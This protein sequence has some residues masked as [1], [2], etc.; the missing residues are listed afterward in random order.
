[1]ECAVI[2]HR[3][4]ILKAALAILIFG[5]VPAAVSKIGLNTPALGIVR[6]TLATAG[7]SLI[8]ASRPSQ[9]GAIRNDFRRA[10]PALA[11]MGVF[12]GLHWLTYFIAIKLGSPSMSELGFSTYGAQL[13]FLGW[14]FGFGRPRAATVAGIVLAIAGSAMCLWG[15]RLG[16]AP[17]GGL[18]V[19]VVSGTLYAALPLLHQRFAAVDAQLRTWAQFAFALPLFLALR[20]RPSGRGACATCCWRCT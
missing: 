5:T 2:A 15:V 16:S 14:A 13:P 7:M 1:M 9:R 4:A 20:R 3:T 10:W 12:F 6:L 17:A 19:G 11:A 8:L 18:G